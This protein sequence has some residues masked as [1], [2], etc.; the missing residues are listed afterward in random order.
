METVIEIVSGNSVEQV[1]G[2]LE[3]ACN[4]HQFGVLAVHDLRAKMRDKGVDFEK[5][6]LVFEVC[7]PHKAK[8]V[9]EDDLRISTALPCRISVFRQGDSTHLATIRPGLMLQM[10]GSPDLAP[11][12]EE[13]ENTL[14]DIMNEAAGP[15]PTR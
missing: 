11:V 12:A 3:A 15:N 6:C 4:R 14:I 8:T 2:E 1:R 5:E 9:L 13:V 7:N 10:F